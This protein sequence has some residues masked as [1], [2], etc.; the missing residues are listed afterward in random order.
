MKTF[1]LILAVAVAVVS[2]AIP[3]EWQDKVNSFNAFFGEDDSSPIGVNGYPDI[4][5]VMELTTLL[6]LS[7]A[8]VCPILFILTHC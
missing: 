3:P 4:Y 5:L 1:F 6:P 7:H 2:A 8:C